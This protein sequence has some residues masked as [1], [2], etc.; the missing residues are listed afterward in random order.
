MIDSER[1]IRRHIH[2]ST[3]QFHSTM[4]PLGEPEMSALEQS[5]HRVAR[6]PATVFN[7]LSAEVGLERDV[8]GVN[9]VPLVGHDLSSQSTGCSRD[10]FV[11]IRE[12]KPIKG[13]L[14]DCHVAS[15]IEIWHEWMM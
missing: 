6:P 4:K 13:S 11:G 5:W 9:F 15:R 2:G 10:A 7:P 8:D 3:F 12:P 14:R 1:R